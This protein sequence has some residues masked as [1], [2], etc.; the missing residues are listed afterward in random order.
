M[1]ILV[2]LLKIYERFFGFYSTS[3]F[4][5]KISNPFGYKIR[6]SFYKKSFLELGTNT[7]FPFGV[8]FT[9][10]NI[11]VGNNV[12]FGPFNNVANVNFGNN[13]VIAQNVSFL[14]GSNQHGYNRLDIPMI[15]QPGNLEII[16]I[17]DDVWIGA[18][19]VITESINKGSIIGSLAMVNK[20]F[21]EYSILGGVPAKI[22]KKR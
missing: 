19:A 20:K 18:N 6:Y 2:F 8:I 14:S 13:I 21:P 12:R 4:L 5:S 11:R 7:S 9:N 1:I 22:I 17:N 15:D 3:L 10:K 16:N